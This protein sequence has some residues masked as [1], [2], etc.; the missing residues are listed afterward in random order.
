L[1]KITLLDYEKP[2]WQSKQG[3]PQVVALHRLAPGAREQRVRD[4]GECD[5][6]VHQRKNRIIKININKQQK[7]K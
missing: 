5:L 3:D 1:E 6:L 2:F 4:Q 7:L